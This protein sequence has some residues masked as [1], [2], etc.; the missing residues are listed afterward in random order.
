V[1]ARRMLPDSGR[2]PVIGGASGVDPAKRVPGEDLNP[3]DHEDGAG[4]E[5]GRSV[6]WPQ[7]YPPAVHWVESLRSCEMILGAKDGGPAMPLLSPDGIATSEVHLAPAGAFLAGLGSGGSGGA[8][9]VNGIPAS[10]LGHTIQALRVTSLTAGGRLAVDRREGPWI[11]VSGRAAGAA[12]YL[13]SL[14]SGVSVA[15]E[16]AW[17]LAD[18]ES[19]HEQG[20]CNHYCGVSRPANECPP[21][22]RTPCRRVSEGAA[23]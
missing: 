14:R 17:A 23:E 11:W 12:G 2:S 13:E 10:R 5:S 20:D 4:G 22:E 6:V 15:L 1:P 9:T 8:S 18:R 7:G 3:E 16:V 21:G 19:E